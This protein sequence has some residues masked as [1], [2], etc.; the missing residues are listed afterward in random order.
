MRVSSISRAPSIEES[1]H[2]EQQAYQQKMSK[3]FANYS[4]PIP[5]FVD[6]MLRGKC[7]FADASNINKCCTD[8]LEALKLPE[9]QDLK[10]I[11]LKNRLSSGTSD[12]VLRILFGKT[13]AEFQMA[14][15]M[16][17]AEYEFNHN[18]YELKRTKFFSQ[19][20]QLC[21]LN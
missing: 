7:L 9:N 6:D 19:L 11:E 10:V 17:A 20:T 15:N 3:I 2:K 12:L 5:F 8:I 13:V 4:K 16:S 14:I 1:V 18:I 21:I